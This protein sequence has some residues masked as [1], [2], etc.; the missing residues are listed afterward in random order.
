MRETAGMLATA[1]LLILYA[2]GAAGC[3]GTPSPVELT[4]ADSG[5]SQEVAVGQ[6]L[7]ITLD[8]NPS[9]GYRWAVDGRL[10]EQLE[11]RGEP[12]YT[13]GSSA[14]GAG[15]TEV[16]TFAGKQAGAGSLRLKYWRSFEPTVAPIATFAV[17]VR[18]R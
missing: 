13:A 14:L 10:P 4:Q 18:V 9:T 11:Q 2:L 7:R 6:E 12:R 15:G 16:W 17:N 3:H 1:M 5:T 8:A